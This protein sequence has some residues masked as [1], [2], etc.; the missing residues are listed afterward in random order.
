MICSDDN[1][2][3]GYGKRAGKRVC[4]CFSLFPSLCFV[5]WTKIGTYYVVLKLRSA[6]KR[7]YHI[8]ITSSGFTVNMCGFDETC[9][10]S[11]CIQAG[12]FRTLRPLPSSVRGLSD[13]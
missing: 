12:F 8:Y 7:F 4:K 10:W 5:I 9:H 2:T 6:G 11:D 3:I 1:R 13:G